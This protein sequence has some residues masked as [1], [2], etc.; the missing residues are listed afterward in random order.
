MSDVA[1]T[2]IGEGA[3]KSYDVLIVPGGNAERQAEQLGKAGRRAIREFVEE[4]GGYVGVCAGGKLATTNFDWSLGLINA[5]TLS[6]KR[7][8]P[9]PDGVMTV[10][11]GKRGSGTVNMELTDAGR[12]IFAG[13]PG[14]IETGFH[15]GPVFLP[16]RQSDLP[17]CL[18]L[19]EY[20][21]EVWLHKLQIGTMVN[22]P[23]MLAAQF[24]KG[25]VI[26]FSSHPEGRDETE[27][28]VARAVLA[29]ARK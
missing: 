18:P 11:M 17:Q 8:S 23:S 10:D 28:L 13:Q 1:L 14:L 3:L 21:S 20:R 4:G 19:G 16:N 25:R 29:T 12:K 26:I 2:D 7:Q 27:P 15:L 9:G 6:D 22:S 24:G 5:Q